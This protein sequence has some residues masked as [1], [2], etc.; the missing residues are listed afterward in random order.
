MEPFQLALNSPGSQVTLAA[1]LQNE[2]FM[3]R[4]DFGGWG[5]M[6]ASALALKAINALSLITF[7]PFTQSR[8][9]DSTAPTNKT[10]VS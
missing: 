7:P 3:V 9:R 10:G 4:P 2:L 1:Q 8:A 5:T 6:R